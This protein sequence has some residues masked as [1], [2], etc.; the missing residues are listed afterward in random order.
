MELLSL[1]F[2]TNIYTAIINIAHDSLAQ[3]ELMRGF[4]RGSRFYTKLPTYCKN[5]AHCI[6]MY[7]IGDGPRKPGGQVRIQFPIHPHDYGDGMDAFCDTEDALGGV[8]GLDEKRGR[9]LQIGVR[10][11]ECAQMRERPGFL[12]AV[13]RVVF[14][15]E[16]R[17][18]GRYDVQN[19]QL[20]LE[21][22][23]QRRGIGH[24]LCTDLVECRSKE[25]RFSQIGW[26]IQPGTWR[27]WADGQDWT[28]ATF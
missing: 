8:A 22:T 9:A 4:D 16:I 24:G 14:L 23:C 19:E 10:R 12:I 11:H 6:A 3:Y 25:Q 1:L 17:A 21:I 13:R 18:M 5:G 28:A 2:R 27:T 26:I 20:A 15:K 7:L